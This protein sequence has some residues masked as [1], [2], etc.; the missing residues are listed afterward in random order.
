MTSK[1]LKHC[2]VHIVLKRINIPSSA[3]LITS[4]GNEGKTLVFSLHYRELNPLCISFSELGVLVS[5]YTT[6]ASDVS[7]SHIPGEKRQGRL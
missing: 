7:M 3:Y 4:N 2:F 5:V 1:V 6:W